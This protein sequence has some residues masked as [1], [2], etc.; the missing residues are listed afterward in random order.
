MCCLV[1][2]LLL[3]INQDYYNSVIII[4]IESFPP[5]LSMTKITFFSCYYIM[6]SECYQN[7]VTATTAEKEVIDTICKQNDEVKKQQVKVK[8]LV[9]R[10]AAEIERTSCFEG[11]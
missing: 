8:N 7:Q 5:E 2:F 9:D 6:F 4:I 10:I 11:R 1:I 3:L